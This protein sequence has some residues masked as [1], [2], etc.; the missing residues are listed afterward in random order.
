MD[1]AQRNPVLQEHTDQENGNGLQPQKSKGNDV[2]SKDVKREDTDPTRKKKDQDYVEVVADPTKKRKDKA[3]PKKK[4][5]HDKEHEADLEKAVEIKNNKLLKNEHECSDFM[6]V[7]VSL[8]F[9]YLC[10]VNPANPVCMRCSL[11]DR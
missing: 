5:K 11:P 1:S 4:T 9:Y 8:L 6:V 7:C 2:K 10:S 3:D